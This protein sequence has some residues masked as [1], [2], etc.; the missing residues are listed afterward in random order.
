MT[1]SEQIIQVIDTLCEKFGIAI[2][3]TSKNILPY[4]ETLCGKLITYE[5][6]SSITWMIMTALLSIASIVAT[7]KLV[8]IFKKGLEKNKS[9]WCSDC[10][11][12]W[13]V[14]TIFAIIGLA[15]INLA[16]IIVWG[17]QIMDIIK[18]VVFPEMYVFE[19]VNALVS[20]V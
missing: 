13:V 15:V 18:C 5:I 2:D 14:A 16:T 17:M 9:R 7:K 11:E 8:P 1:V 10:N 6:V 20:G 4:I 12:G 19:Y 3:W